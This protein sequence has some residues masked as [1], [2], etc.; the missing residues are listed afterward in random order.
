MPVIA[1]ADHAPLEGGEDPA[2]GTVR[3]RT[4]FSADK[5]DTHSMVM[6][7]AEFGPGGTL[8]AHR[9]SPAEIY[10]GLA[11]HG[12]VTIDGVPHE[13]SPNV[14]VFIPPD[15]EHFT[16]AGEEGLRFLYVFPNNRFGEVEYRFSVA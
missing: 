2:F 10:F 12:T 11:G 8:N 7:V 5:T 15:A 16:E 3:W 13:I 9:H 1:N 6:G 4:L 14:A